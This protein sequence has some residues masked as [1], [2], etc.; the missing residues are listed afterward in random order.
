MVLTLTYLM[1]KP[2]VCF[3]ATSRSPSPSQDAKET[4]LRIQEELSD[5]STCLS[6]GQ[7]MEVR[8]T[9][10]RDDNKFVSIVTTRCVEAN[11]RLVSSDVTSRMAVVIH[12]HIHMIVGL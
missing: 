8:L 9:P 1:L 11:V 4:Q 2:S 12:P 5:H 3:I 7:G 6:G 10:N